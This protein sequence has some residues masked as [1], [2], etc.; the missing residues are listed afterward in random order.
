M[1]PYEFSDN[2]LDHTLEE[3]APYF[4]HHVAWSLDG[5]RILAAARDFDALLR[6]TERLG[7]QG[8]EFVSDFIFDPDKV[9]LGGALLSDI[10]P[11]DLILDETDCVDRRDLRTTS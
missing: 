6:E 2:V 11:E 4:E 3:L 7:L 10:S 8:H 9:D 1:I 5:K